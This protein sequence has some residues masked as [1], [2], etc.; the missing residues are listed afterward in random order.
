LF[1]LKRSAL[2]VNDQSEEEIIMG[3]YPYTTVPG[4][5]VPLFEKIRELG[6]P[7]RVDKK[8]LES[9]GFTG[10]NDYTLLRALRYIGFIDKSGIPTEI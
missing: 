3:D 4:K 7:T 5:I 2:V 9:I 6:V 8:W 10:S 1:D